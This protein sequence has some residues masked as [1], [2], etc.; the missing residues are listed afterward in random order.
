MNNKKALLLLAACSIICIAL[1][2]ASRTSSST[3]ASAQELPSDDN[4][5]FEKD[6]QDLVSKLSEDKQQ[7]VTQWTSAARFDSLV[8]FWDREMR[9]GISAEY[10]LKAA[11]QTGNNANLWVEAGNRFRN[12]QPFFKPEDRPLIASKALACYEKALAISPN[13]LNVKTQYAVHLVENTEEPM[14]GIGILREVVGVDSTNVAAQLNLGFFSMKSGQYDKAIKRFEL[15]KKLAPEQEEINFYLAE[16]Y[17]AAGD[18]QEAKRYYL[19][20]LKTNKDEEVKAE[21]ENRIKNL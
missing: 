14:K 21:V 1:L 10:A 2:L 20:F 12:L 13:D 3:E 17:T 4:L 16:A 7:K 18:K 15:V 6:V 19:E 11:E 5:R 9:P 8:R